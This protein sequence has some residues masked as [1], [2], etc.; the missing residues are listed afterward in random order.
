MYS[1]L[2]SIN[3]NLLQSFD[4][5]TGHFILGRM[6]YLL[7]LFG[8]GRRG[9]YTAPSMRLYRITR[10]QNAIYR[11]V[12][13]SKFRMFERHFTDKSISLGYLGLV[14]FR[15]FQRC[16]FKFFP[17]LIRRLVRLHSIIYFE[18]FQKIIS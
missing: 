16:Y 14:S 4:A 2:F 5:I 7:E 11:H 8:R 17:S 15:Y 6:C 13:F 9:I 3:L 10:T 12:P 1:H 18:S